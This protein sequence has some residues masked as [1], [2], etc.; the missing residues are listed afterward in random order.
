M[1]NKASRAVPWLDPW[2]QWARWRGTGHGI[3]LRCGRT[4]RCEWHMRSASLIKCALLPCTFLRPTS[5]YMLGKFLI[6]IS[7]LQVVATVAVKCLA[8]FLPPW[9][10]VTPDKGSVPYNL[11]RSV[12]ITSGFI[13]SGWLM[14]SVVPVLFP[15]HWLCRLLVTSFPAFLARTLCTDLQKVCCVGST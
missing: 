11:A 13:V 10:L 3:E 9:H 7:A 4:M 12:V 14:Q 6:L 2:A 1:Y 5:F 15:C 8:L